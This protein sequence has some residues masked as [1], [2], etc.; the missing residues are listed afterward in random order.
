MESPIVFSDGT[1]V[2]SR[3]A[4]ATNRMVAAFRKSVQNPAGFWTTF[5][6]QA[7]SL[8]ENQIAL[9]AIN[10][11]V[12]RAT[13]LV[14]QD[15]PSAV[16]YWR[17]LSRN[18]RS[19]LRAYRASVQERREKCIA[20]YEAKERARF[21]RQQAAY[22]ARGAAL[23]A[24]N[25]RR[26][27]AAALKQRK[28]ELLHRQV[29]GERRAV[30]R[31]ERRRAR[32]QRLRAH[33]LA[34]AL[35]SPP[36]VK[37]GW[38]W[39]P[40]PSSS[41][42]SSPSIQVGDFLCPILGVER[43]WVYPL[44]TAAEYGMNP[45]KLSSY[46][47][48]M[49]GGASVN[50][51][52]KYLTHSGV[53]SF[54]P[55]RL[56]CQSGI[57]PRRFNLR[58][59]LKRAL[60]AQKNFLQG[61]WQVLLGKTS[62][63]TEVQPEVT[64]APVSSEWMGLWDDYARFLQCDNYSG[65]R[66]FNSRFHS[67]GYYSFC[68]SAPRFLLE[69]QEPHLHSLLED[70][71]LC[72]IYSQVD[73]P[74]PGF[75][76]FSSAS[77]PILCASNIFP[78]PCSVPGIEGEGPH[79]HSLF[80]E[81]T[82]FE[83]AVNIA[84]PHLIFAEACP[85][86]IGIKTAN[87]RL[88]R[89]TS[90]WDI[91]FESQ[92]F[93]SLPLFLGR[94][95]A[96][97]VVEPRVH[98]CLEIE[99][100]V[101]PIFYEES[102]HD[103]PTNIIED[104]FAD[105][106]PKSWEEEEVIEPNCVPH[107]EQIGTTP[108]FS[109]FG[110][111][112]HFPQPH[113][114][115]GFYLPMAT[116]CECCLV[117]EG[118]W[119]DIIDRY[120]GKRCD[121]ERPNI[122]ALHDSTF[123]KSRDLFK[124]GD[125]GNWNVWFQ[126]PLSF[127][128]LE[129]REFLLFERA[130]QDSLFIEKVVAP[131]IEKATPSRISRIYRGFFD[132]KPHPDENQDEFFDCLTLQ[133]GLRRREEVEADLADKAKNEA[134]ENGA[135][136]IIE[137]VDKLRSRKTPVADSAE[138]RNAAH[139][140]VLKKGDVFRSTGV[141]EWF[142]PS[143]WKGVKS[144]YVEPV[145]TIIGTNYDVR[146]SKPGEMT[147]TPL[148]VLPVKDIRRY[149]EE[150]WNSSSVIA[151]D[152]HV[153]SLLPQGLPVEAL[154]IAMDGQSNDAAYAS[155]SGGYMNLG[156][157]KAKIFSLPLLNFSLSDALED[158]ENYE[159]GLYF[160]T[161][162]GRLCG[163]DVGRKAFTYTVVGFSEQKRNALTNISSVRDSF[164]EIVAR[165]KRK[166][167]SRIVAALNYND[168]FS[169]GLHQDM[170][171][172]PSVEY[173]TRPKPTDGQRILNAGM[174]EEHTPARKS[175]KVPVRTSSV[176][177]NVLPWEQP[178][179][180]IERTTQPE[181]IGLVANPPCETMSLQSGLVPGMSWDAAVIFECPKDCKSGDLIL[182]MKM[183]DILEKAGTEAW[184]RIQSQL[185]NN[186]TI[187]GRILMGSNIAVGASLAL[188]CDV[189][190]RLGELNT[191][192]TKLMNVLPTEIFPFGNTRRREFEFNLNELFGFPFHAYFDSFQDIG[193]YLSCANNNAVPCN[194]NWH[195]TILFKFE[196]SSSQA[197]EVTLPVTAG[198]VAPLHVWR[199]PAEIRQG[200]TRITIDIGTDFCSPWE[201]SNSYEPVIPFNLAALGMYIGY[202]GVLV[203]EIVNIGSQLITTDLW[204]TIWWGNTSSGKDMRDFIK[205]PSYLLEGGDGGFR[206]PF[207]A[208]FLATSA[209]QGGAVLVVHT[210]A[211]V[212]APDS[213]D[214]P[215]VF[216]VRLK[217]IEFDAALPPVVSNKLIF[218]WARIGAFSGAG[219]HVIEIAARLPD[220]VYNRAS[221]RMIRHPLS[222]MVAAAGLFAGTMRF[223]FQWRVAGTIIQPADVFECTSVFDNIDIE[224][225]MVH[226][227]ES[228]NTTLDVVVTGLGNFT[229][230]GG[231]AKGGENK[232]RLTLRNTTRLEQLLIQVELLPGFKFRGPTVPILVRRTRALQCAQN[233][234]DL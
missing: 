91:L 126:G 2:L 61:L 59:A 189:F 11:I 171:E 18:C 10:G 31:Q 213:F 57:K 88:V 157:Q 63:S 69:E 92:Q 58:R 33:A 156:E 110:R 150:G 87:A 55:E 175:L 35:S 82:C 221:V 73:L 30:A 8:T 100:D 165:Q 130:L 186:L 42:P 103:S 13:V 131:K 178:I 107:W 214:A 166:Q 111:K 145:A 60:Q 75:N 5:L 117:R 15:G 134:G 143:F 226:L 81:C 195:G 177:H 217:H 26:K 39:E 202:S 234:G 36:P 104:E 233:S 138:N 154:T 1:K 32:L 27:K 216:I 129:G 113:K 53:G 52:T 34:Y 161:T 132:R 209:R 181:S 79:V 116:T 192:P 173:K 86:Y 120:A 49:L 105:C 188:T 24:K 222:H 204:V 76:S 160:A 190:N 71:A 28:A 89:A 218:D 152:I 158:V 25:A 121:H 70:C 17:V 182:A 19:F 37:T 54:I 210:A 21:A 125:W 191:V 196:E 43:E 123:Y 99:M 119:G 41:L 212:V 162:V 51:F 183:R 74:P 151:L 78:E 201:F 155:L 77:A 197:Y 144:K 124:Y 101:L 22:R 133:S 231:G 98:S 122:K 38:E 227:S 223:H 90:C 159:T 168:V 176:R 141:G 46:E 174:F 193:F 3:G 206:L 219:D 118:Y 64:S 109:T 137:V 48:K 224:T 211:G 66:S 72:V 16:A 97:K 127:L 232:V 115:V 80:E 128:D 163:S 225:K 93:H 7:L 106:I 198:E 142:S 67:S 94:R 169:Q 228:R 140:V 179:R 95:S 12:S 148:P 102:H 68:V 205:V 62:K 4:I 199:G 187:R 114:E 40:L 47:D 194:S 184:L 200:R 185:V 208:P 85:K 203:G 56:T 84:C 167:S 50:P 229:T 153:E 220:I 149:A 172:F 6:G 108:L 45:Y 146:L 14:H 207:N 83:G 230:S 139:N 112:R 147:Y 29:E 215:F 135:M 44:P 20:S 65:P 136:S 9:L 23:R 96:P 170:G 164:D 180:R